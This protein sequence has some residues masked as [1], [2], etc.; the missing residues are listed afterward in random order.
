M[1]TTLTY[2]RKKPSDG[3]DSAVWFDALEDNIDLNDE[4]NHNGINSPKLDAGAIDKADT[5]TFDEAD[6]SGSD[7]VYTLTLDDSDIPAS[8]LEAGTTSAN[9]TSLVIMD[10]DV[11]GEERVYLKYTWSAATGDSTEITL[12]SS[13]AF[14]GKV[15][16][17]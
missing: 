11:T 8:Y 12:T 10:T 16:F 6:W 9:L 3:E 15:L 14:N 5:A 7:G 4:H 17:L 1:P 2:G 13:R